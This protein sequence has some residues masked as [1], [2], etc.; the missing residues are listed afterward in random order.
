MSSLWGNVFLHSR[1]RAAGAQFPD[2]V[3]IESQLLEDIVVVLS[4]FGRTLCGN[5]GYAPHLDW[6]ADGRG[7]FAARTVEG[8]DN[9]VGAQLRIVDALLR[10]A[11]RA[12]RHMH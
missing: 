6:A 4:D 11:D 7:Q 9:L 1:N 2:F 8:N 12:K 10:P 3:R 5:L